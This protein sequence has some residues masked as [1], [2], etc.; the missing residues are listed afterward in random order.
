MKTLYIVRHAKSSWENPSLSDHDRPLLETGVRKTLRI[1][2]FLKEKGIRP[3]LL[4]SSTAIR[5]FETAR[6]I[7]RELEYP[8]EK[9]E[10][11]DS[12]YHG[13]ANSIFNQLFGLPDGVGSVMI[14]GHNP[15]FTYFANQFLDPTIENL[16]TSGTVSISFDTDRWTDIT[17]SKYRVDFM[18]TPKMLKGK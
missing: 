8:E 2:E 13:S 6:V 4:L 1:A 15:S 9:I 12:L 3:E 7:A 16:P 18:V 11:S 5:A 17:S 10:V 14:F